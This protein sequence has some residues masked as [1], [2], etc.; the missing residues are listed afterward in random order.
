MDAAEIRLDALCVDAGGTRII[1]EVSLD[2]AARRL[3]VIG[4]NGSGKSTLLRVLD[5]LMRPSAGAV[6]VLGLDPVR[7][8]KALRRRVGFVF[9]N[10][11][12]QIV[13][14]TVREDLA[15]SLRGLRLPR[16]EV[17]ARV[18]SWLDRYGLLDRADVPAHSLSGGQKQTLAIAAVL[19]RE[20][21]LVLADEPTTMLDLGNA[22]RISRLLVDEL[23]GSVVIATH[24]LDLA[25]RCD[26]AIRFEA[27]HIIRVGDPAE[28]VDEYERAFA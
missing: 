10:P 3:A 13:M 15:F 5:G 25:R 16:D 20:P 24:D 1:D 28:V 7:E 27:G 12:T 6:R 18:D 9:T 14:P 21:D 11:D 8:A 22:R 19:I 17:R 23:P 26:L 4:A 2:V